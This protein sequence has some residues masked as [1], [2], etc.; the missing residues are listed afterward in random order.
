MMAEIYTN[1]PIVVAFECPDSMAYYSSGIFNGECSSL[2]VSEESTV[3]A[4]WQE[5]NHAVSAVGW[6]TENGIDYW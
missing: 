1:G 6:G 5:V 2:D 3:I 4:D